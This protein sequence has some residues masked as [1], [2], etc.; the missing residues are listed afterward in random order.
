MDKMATVK[1]QSDKTEYSD[2]RKND[3]LHLRSIYRYFNKF[4]LLK[5][6]EKI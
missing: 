1:I 4:C 5:K 6:K 3:Y 2:E